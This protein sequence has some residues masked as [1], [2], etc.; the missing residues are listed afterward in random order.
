[1]FRDIAGKSVIY[2]MSVEMNQIIGN[3]I[4]VVC[5]SVNM[6]GKCGKKNTKKRSRQ[7][8]AC[9]NTLKNESSLKNIDFHIAHAEAHAGGFA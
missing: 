7:R 2:S 8:I 4:M 6:N 3:A 9:K 1:M 5:F